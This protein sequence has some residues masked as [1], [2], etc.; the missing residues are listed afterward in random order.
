MMDFK[1]KLEADTLVGSFLRSD[2]DLNL[3]AFFNKCVEDLNK[4]FC[5]T[6]ISS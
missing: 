5:F 1:Q 3:I 6:Q 4:Y 2:F